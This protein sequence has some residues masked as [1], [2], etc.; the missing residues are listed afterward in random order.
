MAEYALPVKPRALTVLVLLLAAIGLAWEART[1]AEVFLILQASRVG[2]S[3]HR[4][5]T[6]WDQVAVLGM[7]A[8]GVAALRLG[9]RATALVGASL[10]AIGYGVLAAHAPI[11][12]CGSIVALGGGVLLPCSM[13]AAAEALAW[14]GAVPSTPGPARFAAVAAFA[15]AINIVTNAVDLSRTLVVDLLLGCTA[16]TRWGLGVDRW[17]DL[18]RT[19]ADVP[20]VFGACAAMMA[21]AAALSWRAVVHGRSGGLTARAAAAGP[22]RDA[23]ALA[24]STAASRGTPLV[25]LAIL[26]VPQAV[27]W[28]GKAVSRPSGTVEDDIH[29]VQMTLIASLVVSLAVFALLRAAVLRALP[30]P[31]IQLHGVGLLVFAAGLLLIVLAGTSSGTLLTFGAV[32]TGAGGAVAAGVPLAYAAIAV[33]GR[34][35]TLVVAGWS[36][37][38]SLAGTAGAALGAEKALR[39]PVLWLSALLCFSGGAALL[40]LG[41]ALH[42]RCFDPAPPPTVDTTS[43]AE[44]A[45]PAS[46]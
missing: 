9:P 28:I 10:A 42:R 31:P 32:L 8:G 19:S 35:A 44:A 38:G 13:A 5:L 7:L 14:D 21:L 18:L 40:G 6:T 15:I 39:G 22:Y 45:F 3:V 37:V 46:P 1:V 4:V 36:I 41:R 33:R 16:Q 12:A 11:H 25:G 26:L 24:T 27:Y 2:W 34:V 23:Q 20:K 30:R 17:E 29:F 43:P